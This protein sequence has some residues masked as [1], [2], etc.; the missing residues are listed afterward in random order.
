[1]TIATFIL[2]WNGSMAFRS[3][4][5]GGEKVA[6]IYG[7]ALN[8]SDID[9]D[10]NKFRIASALGLSDLVQALEGN[11]ESQQE[12]LENYVWNSYVFAH[13]ADALQIFPTDAEV[14]DELAQVPGFQTDGKLDPLKLTNFVANTLPTLGFTDSIIDELVREQ[15]RVR[16]VMDLIGATA[17]LSPA[18][19]ENRF[20]EANERMDVSV[21]RLNTGDVEKSIAVSDADAKKEYD[22]HLARYKSDEQR[23][24]SVA[25]FEL[26]D[27]QKDLKGKD[28]TD[29]LQALG[30][31]AWSFAQA[32]VDK[33]ADFAGQAKKLGVQVSLTGF[34]SQAAPDPSLAKAPALTP[35]AFTLSP[36]QPSSDVVEG[37]N[38]Y[39]V[40]H[41]EGSVPSRQLSFDEA[42]P[43][44]IAAIQA[45]RASQ[46]MQTMANDVRDRVLAGLKAGKSFVD[47]AAAAGVKGERIPPFS[48]MDASKMDVPDSQAIIQSAVSLN[49]GQFSD[50]LQTD[51]GGLLVYMNS[52]EPID[53]SV[54]AIGEQV[55]KDRFARQKV[56]E[57][58]E[59]WLRLRKEAARLQFFRNSS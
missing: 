18:E 33:S 58:F 32:V 36:D 40:L 55:D 57:A 11:A 12:A 25:S 4:G 1:M 39:Y 17:D 51:A 6:A 21:I 35:M 41:L 52:R 7:E 50:F 29:A 43:K 38:G 15:V 3:A 48:L 20:M 24:V 59:E 34:F 30:D 13:E 47:A 49:S 22:A 23:K 19:L 26:T 28:R 37:P 16:K 56:V 53:K 9:R 31:K 46:M 14:Q 5:P 8:Q 2:F 44:V 27:A 10:V 42:K 54:A 45:D